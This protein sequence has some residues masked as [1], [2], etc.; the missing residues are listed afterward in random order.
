MRR[1]AIEKKG[2]GPEALKKTTITA[3]CLEPRHRLHGDREKLTMQDLISRFVKLEEKLDADEK[4]LLE[5][6]LKRF[7][8]FANVKGFDVV[9]AG[10]LIY[11]P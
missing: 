10:G 4:G 6:I 2:E 9:W 11:V 8:A 7:V 5:D 1:R 3:T